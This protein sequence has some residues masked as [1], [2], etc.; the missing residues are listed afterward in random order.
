MLRTCTP[1]LRTIRGVCVVS[2]SCR[3]YSDIIICSSTIYVKVLGLRVVFVNSKYNLI[4]VLPRRKN[5]NKQYLSIT[6][7][8]Y[9]PQINTIYYSVGETEPHASPSLILL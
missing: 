9:S 4:W 6:I 2:N 5:L 1:K 7:L 3:T 8:N